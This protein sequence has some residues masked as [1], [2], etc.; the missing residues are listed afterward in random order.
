[1]LVLPGRAALSAAKRQ[2]ALYRARTACPGVSALDARWVHVVAST[3]ELSPAELD[4]LGEMLTYGPSAFHVE[5]PGSQFKAET[6]ETD[7]FFITP[8]RYPI[9]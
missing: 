3:R 6:I 5:A 1:V 8:R 4:Q 9:A 2:T 7:S